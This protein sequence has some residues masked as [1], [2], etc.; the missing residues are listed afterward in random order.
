MSRIG[1]APIAVPAGVEVKIEANNVVTVKG[2]KGTMTRQFHPNM[3]IEQEGEVI[4]V[5]RPNDA[6]EN[7]SLHGLTR[8]LIHNM[9][10]GV[11][12]G[13]RKDL[14]IQGVGYR[15]AKQGSKLTLTLGF[16][17]PVEFEDTDTIKIEL[18]DALHFSI[19]GIDKQEVGQFAAEV[20]GVRPPEPYK[21]KGIRYVGEYVIRKEGKAGKGK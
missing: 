20:R 7:R 17:H 4:R 1:R 2:P 9:V 18:K 14:E 12:E 13:F 19:T 10:V 8:T 15:A 16:S 5:T 11:T 6:K 21:G 3:K